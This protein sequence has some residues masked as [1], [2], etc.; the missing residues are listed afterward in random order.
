VFL[1]TRLAA[2]GWLPASA[3]LVRASRRA[4]G[5]AWA[6]LQ[7]PH[8]IAL[9]LPE[10]GKSPRRDRRLAKVAWA[11]L[12]VVAGV[13]A[14][15]R[16]LL[17]G[18]VLLKA[19]AP[20]AV[21]L[22]PLGVLWTLLGGASVV[23]ILLATPS[24]RGAR[25]WL[26]TLLLWSGALVLAAVLPG[27]V[28]LTLLA[29]VSLF[30]AVRLH[31]AAPATY[32][33]C[34]R[35]AD[36][37][38][39]AV[40]VHE[41]VRE[42]HAALALGLFAVVA[43]GQSHRITTSELPTGPMAF[44]IGLGLLASVSAL[45]LALG[46][47][48]QVTGLLGPAT[49]RL[50]V[51]LE[52][53]LWLREGTVP[54]PAWAAHVEQGGW[55]VETTYREPPGG[56]DLVVG[57][58]RDPRAFRP[59]PSLAA[60][61]L[62]FRLDRRFH[63][64]KRRQFH[65]AFRRLFLHARSREHPHGTGYVFSPHVWLLTGLVRDADEPEGTRGRRSMFSARV[66]GPPYARLFPSRVRRYLGEVLRAL[67]VDL[68][69]WEDAIEWVEIRAVLGVLF[70]T[71]DQGRFPAEERHFAGLPRVRV[72][73]QSDE[74]EDEAGD[75]PGAVRAR[76]LLVLRDRGGPARRSPRGAPGG[77]RPHPLPT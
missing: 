10:T 48:R 24:R 12:L 4:L 27:V 26:G 63:V 41:Y 57:G 21:Y 72:L 61:E 58:P 74:D 68:V 17:D 62:R 9:R 51:P 47:G 5:A 40:P 44:T 38:T 7:S 30:R 31:R 71:Y 65:R 75:Q 15:G 34:R 22:L 39:R 29:G 18:L 60:D 25:P 43:L 69:F 6:S 36:G 50:D 20:Y 42:L 45:F 16:G 77:R 28:V 19:H 8:W 33:V 3:R 11:F 56:F 53:T 67:E 54:R 70:E 52:R 37:T 14:A 59:D 13:L 55:R 64:V 23:G 35:G 46:P 66:I 1:A 76:V 2:A 73:I 49:S 32:H